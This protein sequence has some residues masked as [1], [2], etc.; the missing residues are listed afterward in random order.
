MEKRDGLCKNGMAEENSD[1]S[2]SNGVNA[3]DGLQGAK[4]GSGLTSEW[5]YETCSSSFRSD[6]HKHPSLLYF[7]QGSPTAS[8]VCVFSFNASEQGGDIP[9]HRPR[10]P[11]SADGGR[12]ELKYANVTYFYSRD[13]VER[14]FPS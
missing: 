5:R 8:S 11:S 9:H 3:A 6:L 1:P 12:M 10:T 14:T 13:P 4:V 2:D 7:Q